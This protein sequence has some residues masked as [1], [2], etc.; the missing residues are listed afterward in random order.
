MRP[1]F[2]QRHPQ[3]L[4]RPVQIIEPQAGDLPGAQAIGDQ[5]HQDGAVAQFTPP[6]ALGGGEQT[7]DLVP[8]QPLRNCLAAMEPATA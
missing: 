6:L 1:G 7:Q 2:G 3:R 4:L 8:G 5:H